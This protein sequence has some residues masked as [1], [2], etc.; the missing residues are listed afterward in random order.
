M[1]SKWIE[2]IPLIAAELTE[3]ENKA[4]NLSQEPR[5]T[6]N[7]HGFESLAHYHDILKQA[8]AHAVKFLAEKYDIRS[9]EDLEF[10]VQDH[11]SEYP[12]I[13]RHIGDH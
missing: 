11:S 4:L 8:K 13:K 3:L 6:W 2:A 5:Q 10:E 7:K 1:L 12:G 9:V